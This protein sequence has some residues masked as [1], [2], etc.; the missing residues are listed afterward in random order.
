MSFA[1][2]LEKFWLN[3]SGISFFETWGSM[4]AAVK[5]KSFK[6]SMKK[7]TEAATKSVL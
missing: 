2:S 4:A 5:M 7:R 1:F 3:S 6:Q